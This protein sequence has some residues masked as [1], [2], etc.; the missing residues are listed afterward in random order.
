MKE[1]ELLK[2]QIDKSPHSPEQIAKK[3][4]VSR[5][6]IYRLFDKDSIP[7]YYKDLLKKAEIIIDNH[8][9]EA[10]MTALRVENESLKRENAL[11]TKMVALLEAKLESKKQ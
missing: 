3:I 6:Q 9:N 11:L 4:G 10:N 7:D 2:K 8:G 5:A 1:G